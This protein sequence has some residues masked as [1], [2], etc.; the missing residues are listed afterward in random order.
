[1]RPIRIFGILLIVASMAFVAIGMF[2]PHSALFMYFAFMSTV[3]GFILATGNLGQ[4]S[5][6]AL[7]PH[8]RII[9]KKIEDKQ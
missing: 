5:A 1:M 4:Y 8:S 7:D 6:P 2:V 9:A 3:A